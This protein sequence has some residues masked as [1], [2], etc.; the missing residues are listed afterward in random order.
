M[1]KEIRWFACREWGA[2]RAVETDDGE[3]CVQEEN[4]D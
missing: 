2:I 4:D 1:G 3:S